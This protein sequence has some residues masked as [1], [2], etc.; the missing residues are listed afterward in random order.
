MRRRVMFAVFSVMLLV[1]PLYAADDNPCDKC[2][3]D[4][5]KEMVKCIESAISQEDKKTC[6]EKG[7]ERVKACTQLEC[8]LSTGK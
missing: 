5:N 8:K 7:E 3:S 1:A 4:A 2:K 6:T